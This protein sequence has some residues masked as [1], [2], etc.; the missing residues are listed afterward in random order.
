MMTMKLALIAALIAMVRA[1][2][3]E[4]ANPLQSKSRLGQMVGN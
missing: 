3:W 1:V 2:A 4:A